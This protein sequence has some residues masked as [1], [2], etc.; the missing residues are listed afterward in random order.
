MICSYPHGVCSSNV[1]RFMSRGHMGSN[2]ALVSH[3]SLTHCRIL[4]GI[5]FVQLIRALISALRG[6]QLVSAGR[7]QSQRLPWANEAEFLPLRPLMRS[8]Y[9]CAVKESSSSHEF[10][11]VA[12]RNIVL[13]TDKT[14]PKLDMQCSPARSFVEHVCLS[15]MELHNAWIAQKSVAHRDCFSYDCGMA[16]HCVAAMPV[17]CRG[18]L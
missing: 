5:L 10:V 4:R 7:W 6:M 9:Y 12:Q 11:D 2:A 1:W 15:V 14:P 17:L 13:K 8:E 3:R 18:S 16:C